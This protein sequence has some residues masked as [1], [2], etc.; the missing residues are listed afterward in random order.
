MADRKHWAKYREGATPHGQWLQQSLNAFRTQFMDLI[1]STRTQHSPLTRSQANVTSNTSKNGSE[2]SE[3]S[4]SAQQQSSAQDQKKASNQPS[5]NPVK[6]YVLEQLAKL[7]TTCVII[8][9]DDFTLYKV[10]TSSRKPVPKEFIS[11]NLFGL[12]IR[13]MLR[14][15][16]VG[17][18]SSIINIHWVYT[19]SSNAEETPY[20]YNRLK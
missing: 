11:G 15:W 12:Q 4:V 13:I 9:I 8:R 1:D 7:M 2:D 19:Y 14:R 10:T 3:K 5:G 16:I 20:R 17:L 6:N 18:L